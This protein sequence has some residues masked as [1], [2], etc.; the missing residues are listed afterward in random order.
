MRLQGGPVNDL[1]HR[2]RSARVDAGMSLQALAARA[3]YSKSLLGHLE[4]G[5]ARTL[6]RACGRLR[7]RARGP[8][9]GLRD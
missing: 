3:H 2:L 9:R 6:G 4:T 8:D 5:A 1:G 7:A